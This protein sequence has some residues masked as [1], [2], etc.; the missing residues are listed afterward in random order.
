MRCVAVEVGMV[1]VEGKVGGGVNPV[2][3]ARIKNTKLT[4]AILLFDPNKEI[5]FIKKIIAE[6]LDTQSIGQSNG[7]SKG[8]YGI[9]LFS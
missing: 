8:I 9:R 5:F 4:K 1:T 2:H 7:R 6:S 3:A